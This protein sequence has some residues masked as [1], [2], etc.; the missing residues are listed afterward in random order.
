MDIAALP[1]VE[2]HCHLDGIITPAMVRD[3]Q[4]TDPTF[5]IQAD[6]LERAYPING[7]ESF[8]N[9]WPYARP[10]NLE[11][12][13]PII[14]RYI[15]QLKAQNVRY[16][17]VM[18]PSGKVPSDPAE[19]VA[20]MQGL[21][22]WVNQCEAGQIQV[23]FLL[24][25]RRN[26]SVEDVESIAVTILALFEA[27]LIVG[28]AL[29]GP[30]IGNPAAPFE[31]IFARLHDAGVKVE[32][33][34]GE[35]VGAESVWDALQHGF[36]DRIGHGVNLFDDP[37]LIEIFQERQIHVEIC[38][39]SNVQTGSVAR[40]EDLHA[41]KALEAG[42]NFGIN[43]DDP[44]VFMCSMNSEYALITDVFGFTEDD[45]MAVYRNSLNA[46]FCKELRVAT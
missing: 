8:F 38:P 13:R 31:H 24:G 42:L 34:A 32:I 1:K 46:R 43:T 20:V 18:V 36:P 37:R 25:F 4:R 2:L 40:I 11:H 12:H 45:W 28:V 9:W 29:V 10:A 27:G 14:Q 41:R 21:R 19:A 3:I 17:E 15:E 33:H 6:E 16:F 7:L 5:P 26:R 30:E 35:W 44:G 22:E 23:E 39:S